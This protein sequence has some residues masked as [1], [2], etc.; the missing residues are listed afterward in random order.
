MW[1]PNTALIHGEQS[2][3]LWESGL[4]DHLP[5]G[6]LQQPQNEPLSGEPELW[7]VFDCHQASEIITLKTT[8]SRH[9]WAYTLI[10]ELL[11][12]V[13]A[14]SPQ[15]HGNQ[16]NITRVFFLV[17]AVPS[18]LVMKWWSS[19][20][21]IWMCT[22]FLHISQL[23]FTLV[24]GRD[25]ESVHMNKSCSWICI[26]QYFN[27]WVLLLRKSSSNL[28]QHFSRDITFQKKLMF[29]R[30]HFSSRQTRTNL[31][32]EA[33]IAQRSVFG[34]GMVLCI[35]NTLPLSKFW[36]RTKVEC[37]DLIKELSSKD[38]PKTSLII[39]VWKQQI[40]VISLN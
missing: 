32:M 28:T 37:F 7:P 15:A 35:D 13:F 3:P 8:L 9:I 29:T 5:Q 22:P 21:S 12:I 2:G 19:P 6:I 23:S 26:P 39:S 20:Q 38:H 27:V 10:T 24:S 17:R 1:V 4:W 30:L 11:C 34:A 25:Y 40:Q 31:K 18:R 36:C 16:A 33:D 14:F